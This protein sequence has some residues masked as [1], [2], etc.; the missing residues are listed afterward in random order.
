MKLAVTDANIFID[1]FY[2]KH[3]DLLFRIN[4]EI[5]TTN[6]VIIEL[7][8]HHQDELLKL[9]NDKYLIVYGLEDEEITNLSNY[10][11]YKGLSDSDK[12]V[13]YLSE[14]VDAMVL[15]GDDLVRKTCKKRKIEIHGILWLL[16]QF[17]YMNH[18]KPIDAANKLEELTKYNSRLPIDS[19]EERIKKWR[20]N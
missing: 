2:I 16:D 13:L 14:K 9:K 4:C 5:Y 8:N 19:C 18:I 6:Q 15:S 17:V 1:L 20:S 11:D 12:S 3:I 7:E 10:K